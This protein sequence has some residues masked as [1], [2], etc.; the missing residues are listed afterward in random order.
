M[1]VD[2]YKQQI[3]SENDILDIVMQGI[4]IKD[5][6]ILSKDNIPLDNVI[7]Y[8]EPNISIS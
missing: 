6:N 3:Y 1:I 4:D 7:K 5:F 8:V 2:K